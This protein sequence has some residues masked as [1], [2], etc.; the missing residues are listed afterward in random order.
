MDVW[1]M[2][3]ARVKEVHR[4]DQ[5]IEHRDDSHLHVFLS[6]LERTVGKELLHAQTF[7]NLS[8]TNIM[9]GS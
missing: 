1:T 3:M 5:S 4:D 7:R 9:I 2:M 8:P 6:L